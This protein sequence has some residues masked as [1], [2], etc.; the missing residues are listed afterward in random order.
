MGLFSTKKEYDYN[1]ITD[2]KFHEEFLDIIRVIIP[3]P[4]ISA[5]L[6]APYIPANFAFTY[7][8]ETIKIYRIGSKDSFYKTYQIVRNNVSKSKSKNVNN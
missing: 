2:L 4:Q 8:G 7:N 5:S 6:G 1:K 3:M